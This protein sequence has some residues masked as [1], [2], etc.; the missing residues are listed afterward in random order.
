MSA[1]GVRVIIGLSAVAVAATPE[2]PAVLVTRQDG[3]GGPVEGLPFGSFDPQG[4]RTFELAVRD[5]VTAQT[6]IALGWV[7]QLYTFGDR[8][9][10]APRADTGEGM[11]PGDRVVSV[12]YLALVR[13]AGPLAAS[14]ACWCSWQRFFPWEDRRQAQRGAGEGHSEAI[15][16]AIASG[17]ELWAASAPDAATRAARQA[18]AAGA[19]GLAGA[20]WA[21]ERVLDRYELLY[22]AGLVP[23]AARDRARAQGKPFDE[24]SQPQGSPPSL[25]GAPMLSDH[26]RILAT[27][28]GR[29]RAKIR[30]RPVLFDLVP[31]TFTLSDLQMLAEGVCGLAVHK[32]NFRRVVEKSGL[33]APT[34]A[35]RTETGGRPAQLFAR[36]ARTGC[37]LARDPDPRSQAVAYRAGAV[38]DGTEVTAPRRSRARWQGR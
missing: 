10:E 9:R 21:D 13:E 1:S 27:A 36:A 15:R 32:Q 5:F 26:R 18:R 20:P 24:V 35:L 19:F 2:G 16:A 6:G 34:G 25:T 8:G 7:E 38:A 17:L 4:H 31:E 23:E 12:G 29:L 33:V 11:R 3:P 30:Y 22:E 37:R 14:G 28:I